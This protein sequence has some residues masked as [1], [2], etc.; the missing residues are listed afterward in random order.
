MFCF[1]LHI[2]TR[3]NRA[4][5]AAVSFEKPWTAG[6]STGHGPQGRPLPN[7][8]KWRLNGSELGNSV[9]QLFLKRGAL[10]DWLHQE[11]GDSQYPRSCDHTGGPCGTQTGLIPSP[12]PPGNAE[13]TEP[14]G[15]K[16][17]GVC[18][19]R[20]FQPLQGK[21]LTHC[22]PKS[23]HGSALINAGIQRAS[24]RKVRHEDSMPQKGRRKN[25]KPPDPSQRTFYSVQS[26]NQFPSDLSYNI[27]PACCYFWWR[28]LLLFTQMIFSAFPSRCQLPNDLET[29]FKFMREFLFKRPLPWIIQFR[30]K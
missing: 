25:V 1:V 22:S 29:P 19:R 2:Y 18:S 28:F 9:L 5:R 26:V 16:D 11:T 21:G 14:E 3:K 27:W 15:G 30:C 12:S 17:W 24:W 13:S 20:Y 6:Q 7:I 8:S 4:Q 23:H 10:P